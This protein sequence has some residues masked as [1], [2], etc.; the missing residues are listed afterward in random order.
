MIDILKTR[1][2]LWKKKLLTMLFWLLLP[3]L[4]TYLFI[5]I[6][7]TIQDDSKVPIGIVVEDDSALANNLLQSISNSNLV[8]VYESNEKEALY[9]LEKH[10]VDSVFII[11]DEFEVNIKS[12]LR[13]NIISSYY[14]EL[15]FAYTPVKEMIVSL[16][17]EESGRAKATNFILQMNEEYNGSDPWSWEEIQNKVR[18]VQLNENLLNTAFTYTGTSNSE[19]QPSLISWNTWTIW[20][21]LSLLSSLFLFDWVIKERALT[22]SARFSFMKVSKWSYYLKLII[23]YFFIFFLFDLIAIALFTLRLD[24]SI[25]LRFIFILISFRLMLCMLSFGLAS[26]FRKAFTYYWVSILLV[27][28]LAFLTGAI[29]PIHQIIPEI[30]YVNYFNPLQDFINENLT[31][32][33]GIIS[34]LFLIL[35]LIRKEVTNA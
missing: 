24:Q 1:L 26:F 10:E 16:V 7:N 5:S 18:Q 21:I 6:V 31:I 35:T 4:G 33:W 11:H 12:G 32:L 2:L 30:P 25:S 3:V 8:Q 29:I 14:T 20:A 34:F 22:V 19:E 9:K 28:V 27:I 17:Q 13:K 15:S 23:L